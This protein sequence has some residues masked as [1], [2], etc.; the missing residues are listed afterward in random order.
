MSSEHASVASEQGHDINLWHPRLGH[1]ERQHLQKTISKQIVKGMNVSKT[2]KLSF[3]EGC[4][5]GKMHRKPFKSVTQKYYDKTFSIRLFNGKLEEEIA[6]I[7]G[8]TR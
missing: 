2:V 8:A 7:H 3:C 4:V 5:E 6:A 1:L